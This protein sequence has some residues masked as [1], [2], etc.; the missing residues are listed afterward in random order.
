MWR[1]R[2]LVKNHPFLEDFPCRMDYGAGGGLC[3][4]TWGPSGHPSHS[5]N[6][7]CRHLWLEDKWAFSPIY[8]PL[9]MSLP[10]TC[11]LRPR[12]SF[13]SSVP[14]YNNVETPCGTATMPN[15]SFLPR[16][17]VLQTQ[18]IPHFAQSNKISQRRCMKD[19]PS[20]QVEIFP[21]NDDVSRWSSGKVVWQDTKWDFRDKRGKSANG[22]SSQLN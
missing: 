14:K 9:K 3:E 16:N 22:F 4:S 15:A 6:F 21:E 8:N 2:S 18:E 12:E 13:L 17:Y 11:F 7:H 1:P 5:E 10:F 19:F 20:A